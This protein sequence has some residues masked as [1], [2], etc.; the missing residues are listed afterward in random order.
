MKKKIVDAL[1]LINL[2]DTVKQRAW[3]K[4]TS[5]SRRKNR[6]FPA[7]AAT[8]AVFI[9]IILAYTLIPGQTGN[10]FTAA[11]Y[12]VVYR[13]DGTAEQIELDIVP[14]K[15]TDDTSEHFENI[16]LAST[17]EIR[18]GFTDGE[19]MYVNL[20]F[21]IS[22]EN[23]KSVEF[24]LDNGFFA[25]QKIDMDDVLIS[26]R[27]D[28]DNMIYV[29]FG[30][31]FIPLGDRMSYE[32]MKSEDYS[33]AVVAPFYYDFEFPFFWNDSAP[34][35]RFYLSVL[36]DVFFNN[37]EKQSKIIIINTNSVRTGTYFHKDYGIVSANWLNL[38]D[39]ADA[40][41]ISESVHILPVYNDTSNK[42]GEEMYV[43][44]REQG[45]ILI[46]RLFLSRPGNETGFEQRY[47]PYITD[48][49]VIVPLIRADENNDFIAME[50]MLTD[51]I[52]SLFLMFR[53][54]LL[55]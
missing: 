36:I 3:I 32:D 2:N 9:I 12:T 31:D 11:A 16:I 17:Y 5:E 13:A 55:N 15:P 23:I 43:W 1:D 29:V 10:S 45:D 27:D 14:V 22:G 19:H 46:S 54:Q 53:E 44:E 34:T 21:S 7:F 8:A 40:T 47:M 39:L 38:L 41:L 6:A 35:S 52:A 26:V 18:H 51:E 37:G 4:I 25:K 42:W 33:F 20:A 28:N 50:Y 49:K 48:G 30:T 24:S